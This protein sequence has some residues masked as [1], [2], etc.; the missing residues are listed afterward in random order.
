MNRIQHFR[1]EN[2]QLV[3]LNRYLTFSTENHSLGLIASFHSHVILNPRDS[4]GTFCQTSQVHDDSCRIG[5]LGS[6]TF[7]FQTFNHLSQMKQ[8]SVVPHSK[9]HDSWLTCVE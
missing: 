5:C 6:W 7:A 2:T 8:M 9:A 4:G 3:T 1:R